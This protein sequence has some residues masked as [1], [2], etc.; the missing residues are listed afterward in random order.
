[1]STTK[2]L[3]I[4]WNMGYSIRT[5]YAEMRYGLKI[6]NEICAFKKDCGIHIPIEN[7]NFDMAIKRLYKRVIDFEG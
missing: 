2:R 3:K 5:D 1:M 6:P 7:N 4:I